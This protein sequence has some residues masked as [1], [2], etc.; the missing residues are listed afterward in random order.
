MRSFSLALF[1]LFMI[2][3]VTKP[4]LISCRALRSGRKNETTVHREPTDIDDHGFGSVST[5]VKDSAPVKDAGGDQHG[6][7]V[8][9]L[10]SSGPSREGPGH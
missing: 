3:L 8:Y 10:T 7:Q 4:N 1:I 5:T 6:Q 9:K 2:L